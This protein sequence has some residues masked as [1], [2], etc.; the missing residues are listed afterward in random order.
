MSCA[1]VGCRGVENSF[2]ELKGSSTIV[3]EVPDAE[4]RRLGSRRRRRVSGGVGTLWNDVSWSEEFESVSSINV[5]V[6]GWEELRGKSREC[7]ERGVG[8]S[9]TIVIS[10]ICRWCVRS[11]RMENVGFEIGSGCDSCK[12]PNDGL[13]S[14]E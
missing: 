12:S 11:F 7:A 4:E 2:G 6:V 1:L 8:V 3:E 5:G 10:E 14:M 9:G 13:P